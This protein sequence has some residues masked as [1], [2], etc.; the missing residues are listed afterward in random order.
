MAQDAARVNAK[1]QLDLI[2]PTGVQRGEVED[3]SP[4]VPCIEIIPHGLGAMGVEVVPHDVHG[5]FRIGQ[6]DLLHERHEIV[7]RAPIGATAKN[8]SRVHIHRGDEGLRTV[9]DV[10]EFTTPCSTRS[11]CAIRMLAFDGLNPGLLVDRQ[12]DRTLRRLTIQRTDLVDLLSELRVGTV[13]PLPNTVRTQIARLQDALQMT[14]TDLLDHT[15]LHGAIDQFVQRRCG[16]PLQ[17]GGL[18]G[19]RHQLQSLCVADAPGSARPRDLLQPFDA[20]LGQSS[21]PMRNR[22]H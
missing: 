6:C 10:L 20:T 3:E 12:H 2:H 16:S 4:I 7:L 5:T 13:Q 8:S 22:L 15:T 19:Q 18:A 21:A 1:E 11:R 14:A 9:A 17:L